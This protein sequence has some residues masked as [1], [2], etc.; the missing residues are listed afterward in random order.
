MNSRYILFVRNISWT[1]SHSDLEKYFAT[2]G[3]V[4]LA[5]VKF[6]KLGVNTG[7]GI[8]EFYDRNAMKAALSTVHILDERKLY[9]EWNCNMQDFADNILMPHIEEH[10]DN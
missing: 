10:K 5:R 8:V 9:I 2:F 1:I 3:D 7:K 4:K 6:S